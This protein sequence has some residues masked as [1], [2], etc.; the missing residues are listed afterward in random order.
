M[1]LT[2]L[3]GKICLVDLNSNPQDGTLPNPIV[4]TGISLIP[5]ESITA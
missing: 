2:Q 5:V 3:I 1:P 4:R